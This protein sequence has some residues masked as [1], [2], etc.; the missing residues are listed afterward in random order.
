MRSVARCVCVW[1]G[2]TEHRLHVDKQRAALGKYCWRMASGKD[3][4][5]GSNVG[6]S[7]YAKGHGHASE[8]MGV[9][10]Q[11]TS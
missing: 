2:Y 5:K 4:L 8:N 1:H 9:A 10:S 3:G 6:P 11:W 7:M